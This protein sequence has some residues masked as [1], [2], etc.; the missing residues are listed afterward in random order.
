MKKN[1]K[2]NGQRPR[3]Y[4]EPENYDE[5]GVWICPTLLEKDFITSIEKWWKGTI[6]QLDKSSYLTYL[7]LDGIDSIVYL[8]EFIEKKKPELLGRALLWNPRLLEHP[9]IRAQLINWLAGAKLTILTRERAYRKPIESFAKSLL[10]RTIK[11]PKKK[12]DLDLLEK[13][14]GRLKASYD[15]FYEAITKEFENFKKKEKKRKLNEFDIS[16]ILKKRFQNLKNENG[17]INGIKFNRYFNELAKERQ[18]SKIARKMLQDT[19]KREFNVEVGIS[20]LKKYIKDT[21]S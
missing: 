4:E 19:L 11:T 12:E 6:K 9:D 10:P 1:K 8:K 17:D 21:K 15:A 14:P 13:A 3:Y 20:N 5:D 16:K 7:Q 18:A 2:A